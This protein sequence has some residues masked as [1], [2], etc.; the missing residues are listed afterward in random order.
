MEEGVVWAPE[1]TARR[2]E[3][4]A[5]DDFKHAKDPMF[6]VKLSELVGQ[7]A[8]TDKLTC[9]EKAVASLT[10]S[11]VKNVKST[12]TKWGNYPVFVLTGDAKGTAMFTAF[13]GLN[14]PDGWALVVNYRVPTG[15]GHPT[16][17]EKKIWERFINESK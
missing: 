2:F 1:R 9:E 10:S 8:G 7:V 14:S 4:R 3:F 15:K 11:G 5:D 17:E 6:Y 16:D 13:V 12:K